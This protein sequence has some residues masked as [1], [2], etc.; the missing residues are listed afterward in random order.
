MEDHRQAAAK[1]LERAVNAKFK[2]QAAQNPWG[3]TEY[4]CQA[5]TAFCKHGCTKLAAREL[6]LSPRTVEHYIHTARAKTEYLGRSIS[7]F[8][9]Y[10]RWV[11]EWAP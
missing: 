8:L 4:E 2:A 5:L 10:D 11:R 7:L 1:R 9:A 3:F 6:E